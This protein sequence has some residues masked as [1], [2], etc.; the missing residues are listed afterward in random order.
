[1][2][3]YG[4]QSVDESDIEAV[5]EVLRSDY[6]TTGPMVEAFESAFG[7]YLG[8]K[9]SV[10]VSSATAG[11]HL[12]IK[13]LGVAYGKRVLTSANT[14]L[15]SSTCGIYEGAT[16]LFCDVDAETGNMTLETV[17]AAWVDGTRAVVVVHY[18]GQPS[19]IEAISEYARAK[20]AFVIEDASHALGSHIRT[21][22]GWVKCGAHEFAD[23]SVFSFHPVKSMTTAEG[24]MVTTSSAEYAKRIRSLR[25]HGIVRDPARFVNRWEP[26]KGPWFHEMHALG[27]NYRLS[28][29]HCALG[30]SQLK[31]LD[32]NLA[33]RREIHERYN[34][35]FQNVEW[36]NAPKV[37]SFVD[38]ETIGWHIY[39]AS[40]DW[41]KL[42]K[43]RTE[44]MTMLREAGIGT[45]VLYIPVYVQ[46]YFQC[47]FGYE[48]GICPEAENFYSS[49]LCLPLY[50]ELSDQDVDT[51]IEQ[52]LALKHG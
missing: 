26:E 20:G 24:G 47:H 3:P 25:H 40:F 35:A 21:E 32:G 17:K 37:A 41:A 18:G 38:P 49:N 11:L 50:A 27:C 8:A 16:P 13:A 5:V 30:L 22:S 29:I 15:A 1:M 9:H 45:Q 19:D 7:E 52:V 23:L 46:P 39:P 4:R 31:R 48:P 28:D 44:V 12:C 2:I 42:G 34:S 43:T 36:V 14:F 33:R 51:V 6:L 10:A